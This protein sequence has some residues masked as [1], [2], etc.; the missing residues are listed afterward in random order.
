MKSQE[1]QESVSNPFIHSVPRES[2]TQR[3]DPVWSAEIALISFRI[4]SFPLIIVSRTLCLCGVSAGLKRAGWAMAA[5]RS[6]DRRTSDQRSYG[7][8]PETAAAASLL[9]D[10]A[11]SSASAS[12]CAHTRTDA[13]PRLATHKARVITI[14]QRN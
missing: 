12:A 2:L 7:G 8:S 3:N 13:K 6:W 14:P 5:V 4:G 9:A 1:V 11:M 10:G